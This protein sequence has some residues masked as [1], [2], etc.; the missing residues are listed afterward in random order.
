M[1]TF[2]GHL[3]E[4][5][6]QKRTVALVENGSWAPVAAR[7]MQEMLKESKGIKF[8]ENTVKIKAAVDEENIAQME[9]LVK[10]LYEI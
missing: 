8:A 4:R 3:K 1:K 2:I 7:I 10:E 5:N 9:A 6:Y